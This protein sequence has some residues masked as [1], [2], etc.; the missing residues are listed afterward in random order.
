MGENYI[1]IGVL[2]ILILMLLAY[3]VHNNDIMDKKAIKVYMI[4]ILATAVVV[5]TESVGSVFEQEHSPY[6]KY[7]MILDLIGFAISPYIPLLLADVFSNNKYKI[8]WVAYLPGCIN[9][10][11][12]VLTPFLGL[13]FY[14][15]PEHEYFR[16]PLFLVYVISYIWAVL[17]FFKVVFSTV[18]YYKQKSRYTVHLLFVYIIVG[19]S[20]QVIWPNIH[21]TWTCVT[22]GMVLYYAFV[23]EFNDKHDVLTSLF[24]RRTFEN[25]RRRLET[26]GQ[27]IIVL[28]DIDDFK[29]VNDTSGHV[30]GDYCLNKIGYAISEAFFNIGSGFR[31]GGDEL[32][33]LSDMIEEE[34]FENALKVFEDKIKMYRKKDPKFPTVSYGYGVYQKREYENIEQSIQE[35]DE[36]MY[37]DKQRHKT[38]QTYMSFDEVLDKQ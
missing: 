28:F 15:S 12:V 5:F 35:V 18:R 38:S 2:N 4:A 23:C 11:V 21:T 1:A 36:K 17:I 14:F 19:T 9:L 27:A 37:R 24:N 33:V 25:E 32:C 26:E 22:L 7:S 30:Y 29:L 6:V 8:H 13:L 34:K 3:M 10:I 20:I 31:I 16:G